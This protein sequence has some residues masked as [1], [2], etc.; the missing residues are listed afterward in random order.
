MYMY[1][2]NN[3]PQTQWFYWGVVG[4]EEGSD[5]V[6]ADYKILLRQQSG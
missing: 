3:W 4:G 1:N 2:N 5:L 6:R